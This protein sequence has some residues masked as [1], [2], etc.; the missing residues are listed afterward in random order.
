[1]VVYTQDPDARL[2]EGLLA[3]QIGVPFDPE[4]YPVLVQGVEVN[5]KTGEMT[6]QHINEASLAQIRHRRASR[7]TSSR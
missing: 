7:T 6:V 1:M 5:A 4:L 2:I 3:F